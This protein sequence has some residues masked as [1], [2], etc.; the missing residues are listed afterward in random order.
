MHISYVCKDACIYV[1]MHACIHD[2]C[3][4]AC[5]Y[6]CMYVSVHACMCACMYVCVYI[7][8]KVS[9]GSD[10]VYA[11]EKFRKDGVKDGTSCIEQVGLEHCVVLVRVH[12][13]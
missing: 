10:A 2:V 9:I 6:V 5:M 13:A 4:Y 12:R 1:S 3:M 8:Y 11:A 7:T